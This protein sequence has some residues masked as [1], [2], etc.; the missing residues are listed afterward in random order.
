MSNIEEE[1]DIEEGLPERWQRLHR[2]DFD[3]IRLSRAHLSN[4]PDGQSLAE[5]AAQSHRRRL[6]GA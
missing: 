3:A 5:E 4:S 6:R 2:F 1:R